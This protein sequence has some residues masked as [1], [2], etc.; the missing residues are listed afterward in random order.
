MPQPD[1]PLDPQPCAVWSPMAQDIA[2][3]PQAHFLNAFSGIQLDD[4]DYRTHGYD[5]FSQR[6]SPGE[7]AYG[8]PNNLSFTIRK[9][10]CLRRMTSSANRGAS[11]RRT[12]DEGEGVWMSRFNSAS[13]GRA[14]FLR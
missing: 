14:P 8:M 11:S 9:N 4:A 10:S 1:W 6:L 5:L 3:S 7:L 2:H 12:S 13:A